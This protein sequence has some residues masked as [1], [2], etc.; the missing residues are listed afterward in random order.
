MFV[1][2]WSCNDYAFPAYSL[3]LVASKLLSW[4]GSDACFEDSTS[5]PARFSTGGRWFRQEL[6]ISCSRSCYLGWGGGLDVARC[7]VQPGQI[8]VSLF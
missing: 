2:C 6:F 1:S 8:A 7:V 5:C 3:R 4:Y